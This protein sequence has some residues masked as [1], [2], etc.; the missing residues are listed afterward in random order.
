M[1]RLAN[2]SDLFSGRKVIPCHN[3]S[4]ADFCIKHEYML[5]AED[6]VEW[7]DAVMGNYFVVNDEAGYN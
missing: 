2:E 3:R 7:E 5:D 1:L 6:W 4:T